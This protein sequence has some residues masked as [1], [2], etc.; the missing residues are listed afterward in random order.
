MF[1]SKKKE[2]AGAAADVVRQAVAIVEG[3][4]TAG[5]GSVPAGQGWISRLAHTGW[6]ELDV[7][8]RSEPRHAA[9]WEGA[10]LYLAVELRGGAKSAEE[11]VRLQRDQLIPLELEMLAGHLDP[12]TTPAELVRMVRVSS[13]WPHR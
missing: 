5:S 13:H 3:R 12:P 2:L 8:A 10:G 1:R 4:H 9:T 6:E 7:L 11:L